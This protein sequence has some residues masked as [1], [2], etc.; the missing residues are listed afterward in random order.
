MVVTR[1]DD[2][3]NITISEIPHTDVHTAIENVDVS[4]SRDEWIAQVRDNLLQADYDVMD[5]SILD[6]IAIRYF[7]SQ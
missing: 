4:V 2:G 3:E 7:D 6:A 5:E 1:D